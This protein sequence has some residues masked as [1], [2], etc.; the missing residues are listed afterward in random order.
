[1]NQR[2]SS[3]LRN[4]PIYAQIWRF[5]FNRLLYW[6]RREHTVFNK[7]L[8]I[9]PGLEEHLLNSEASEVTEIAELVFTVLT[10]WCTT[11][12]THAL[13]IATKGSLQC[14]IQRCKRSERGH[15]WLDHPSWVIPPP[16][17]CMECQDQSRL[18]PWM[19]RGSFMSC[20][21]G[22]VQFGVSVT[23]PMCYGSDLRWC[24]SIKSKLQNGEI[25]AASNQWPI[26]LY[27]DFKFNPE[28]PWKGLLCSTI[29]VLVTW[30]HA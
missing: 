28:E 25:L 17:H 19:H 1:M 4:P 3:L 18:Q 10:L 22:L 12:V 30:T 29:L 9:I 7:L 11:T 13:L 2:S 24:G 6:Q 21:Y 15:P 27:T 26:F 23:F 8:Q 16:S 5:A 20:R 14:P